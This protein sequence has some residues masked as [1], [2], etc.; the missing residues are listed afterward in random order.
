MKDRDDYREVLWAVADHHDAERNVRGIYGESYLRIMLSRQRIP[1]EFDEF[2][3]C[4]SNLRSDR[5]GKILINKR[6]SWTGFREPMMRGY[7][8]LMAES[9]GVAIAL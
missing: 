9:G 3:A 6:R 1:L 5:H 7:V 2:Q 4:L 8:R